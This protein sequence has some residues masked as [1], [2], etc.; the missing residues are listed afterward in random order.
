MEINKRIKTPSCWVL[1]ILSLLML[2]GCGYRLQ[3]T[4]EDSNIRIKLAQ[5]VPAASLDASEAFHETTPSG[6]PSKTPDTTEIGASETEA[7]QSETPKAD[8][9]KQ[10]VPEAEMAETGPSETAMVKANIGETESFFIKEAGKAY[11]GNEITGKSGLVPIQESSKQI[12]DESARENLT[13]DLGQ[14]GDQLN[15]DPLFYPYYAMLDSVSQAVYRQ[16]YA[17]AS[18]LIP[19]FSP[20]KEVTTTQLGNIFEAVYNDHPDLFWLDNTYSYKYLSNGICAEVT[21]QFN[22][23]ARDLNASKKLF[24]QNAEAILA[25]ARDLTSDYEKELF[26][27]DSLVEHVDYVTSSPLNQSAYSALV[28]GKTVCSGYAKAFQYLL[29]KLNIP[30]YLATGYSRENHAWN[31]VRLGDGYYNIDVTWD[32]V[33]SGIYDFF[34]K[35]DLDFK[36]THK[37]QG[38]SLKLPA[39]NGGEYSGLAPDKRPSL[40]DFGMSETDVSGNLEDYYINCYNQIMEQGA[41]S[42][43]FYNVIPSTLWNAIENAYNTKDY[44][45]G[46]ADRVMK[47]LGARS[48]QVSIEVEVLKGDYYLLKHTAS[49]E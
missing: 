19:T 1:L 21:L 17:N 28:N 14:T 16:I 18:A 33:D 12:E 2:N 37:R 49:I 9:A 22:E 7:L 43:E 32:D 25:G 26:V 46:Y 36:S 20:V 34:N 10:N 6:S 31:I 35:T 11:D 45:Y 47:D 29:Q 27:H 41:G 40:E 44:R 15:F 13:T 4:R 30:C 48:Y 8:T 42:V 23:T 5:T 39:C 24:Q 3:I 38:M